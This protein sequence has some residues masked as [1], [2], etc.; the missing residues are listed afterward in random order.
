MTYYISVSKRTIKRNLKEGANDPPYEIRI[1]KDDRNPVRVH[2]V[3]YKSLIDGGSI[4][5]VY[6]P[7][8][9]L[10]SRAVCWVEVD[11]EATTTIIK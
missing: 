3:S 11:A 7:V 9:P 5:F 1:S 6:D 2:E 8:H 4:R 10:I